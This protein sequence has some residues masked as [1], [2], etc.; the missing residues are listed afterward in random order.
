MASQMI[1]HPAPAVGA[2]GAPLPVSALFAQAVRENSNLELDWLWL[3]TQVRV[4]AEQ[5]YCYARALDI[6][7]SSAPAR[8]ALAQFPP[9]R[10]ED[11]AGAAQDLTPAPLR[12]QARPGL[13]THWPL[14]SR[15]GRS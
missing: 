6:N 9:V 14:V 10:V 13:K 12:P 1:T 7:P 2:G 8:R 3:A 11:S 4:A 15:P 5:R